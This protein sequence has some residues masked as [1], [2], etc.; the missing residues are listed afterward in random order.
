LAAEIAR[1]IFE[2]DAQAIFEAFRKV[3]RKGSPYAYQVLSDR[4]YGKLKETHRIEHTPFEAA[5]DEDIEKRIAELK[6]KLGVTDIT[7]EPKVLPRAD[8]PKVQ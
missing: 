8:D 7:D 2:Q 5:S 6:A 4:A 1:A 3:L